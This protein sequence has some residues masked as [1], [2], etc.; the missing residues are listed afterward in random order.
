MKICI[1]TGASIALP[2]EKETSM[3]SKVLPLFLL[4]LFLNACEFDT[5]STDPAV[6]AAEIASEAS[7]IID[8]VVDDVMESMDSFKDEENLRSV[9][10]SLN[11]L[12][13]IFDV[14]ELQNSS[15][16][17]PEDPQ[18]SEGDARADEKDE[19]Y[20]DEMEVEDEF[21][22]DQFKA[23][24]KE[25]LTDYIFH[26]DNVE[27]ILDDGAVFLLKGAII[28]ATEEDEASDED[29]EE[30][31]STVD[32]LQ[33]RIKARKDHNGTIKLSIFLGKERFNPV[34]LTLSKK[35]L[36][37]ELDLGEIKS[38][39]EHIAATLDQDEM[40]VDELQKLQGRIVLALKFTAAKDLKFSASVLSPIKVVAKVDQELIK[41]AMDAGDDIVALD[42]NGTNQTADAALNVPQVDL[43][44]PIFASNEGSG[45]QEPWG[46][47]NAD[48]RNEKSI[49]R[50]AVYLP[51]LSLGVRLTSETHDLVVTNIGLGQ[52]TTTLKF[53]NHPIFSLD[54][55][56]DHSRAFDL[57]ITPLHEEESAL[58]NVSPALVVNAKLALGPLL[59]ALE[60]EGD[61]D[62]LRK[63]S[64]SVAF[65]GENGASM[66]PL[67]GDDRDFEGGLLMV[68]GALTLTSSA[69]GLS[70]TVQTGQCLVPVEPQEA[71]ANDREPHPFEL[72]GAGA[73]Y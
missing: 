11:L 73:C 70:R 72:V 12:G 17:M 62:F 30:C 5:R 48:A 46:G 61:P 16:D 59:D 19:R 65:I 56:K 18:R 44:M 66:K 49:G 55:N 25:V 71:E 42:V 9:K 10:D 26:A 15:E 47:D 1:V 22:P 64:L 60:S 54:L 23:E 8:K 57:T 52:S 36:E 6:V 29:L 50:L 40:P 35:R 2:K 51:G 31:Q 63:D 27:E 45:G 67:R 4:S 69:A 33:V 34:K 32:E 13:M 28:C 7:L 58:F 41:F 68:E 37:L 20:A 24:F 38:S 39:Y 21:D 14:E 3:S 53:N 43:T